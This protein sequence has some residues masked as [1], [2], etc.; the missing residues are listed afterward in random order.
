MANVIQQAV[1][2][3]KNWWLFLLSGI[4][5]IA[6]AIWVFMNPG[7]SY[8]ALAWLFIVLVLVNGISYLIFSISNREVLEGWGWYLAGGIFEIIIGIFLVYYPDISLVIL[9]LVVGFWFLFRGIQIIGA[10]LDLKQYGF[11]DWGWIMLLGVALT[12]MAFLMILNPVFAVFNVVYLTSLALIIFGIANIM[13]SMKLKKIKSKTIDKV[14]AVKKAFKH[15]LKDLKKEVINKVK[16]MSPEEQA[17][18]DKTFE[19]YETKME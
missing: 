15:S 14:E 8:V 3:V 16:E 11:L 1:S 19:D 2:L 7:E 12:I 6:G 9:P 5:L 18:L 13:I 10:S 17:E 4:L